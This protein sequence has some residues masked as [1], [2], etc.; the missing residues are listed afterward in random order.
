MAVKHLY[1]HI[2]FCRSRCAYCDFASEP[3]GPHRRSGRVRLYLAALRAELGRNAPLLDVPLDTVYLGGGTPS[4]LPRDELLALVGELAALLPAPSGGSGGRSAEFTMEANPGNLDTSLLQGLA[5]AGVTRLSIGIQ[6]FSAQLR[7]TL[8][9][10]VT[11]AEIAESLAAIRE[12][13]WREWNLDLVFGIPGQTRPDVAS[14]L[15]AALAAA[16]PH[17]SLYDLTYSERYSRLLSS[18]AASGAGADGESGARTG[19]GADGESSA[20]RG[21]G[22]AAGT[23]MAAEAFAEKWYAEAV[24]TLVDAGYERYEVSNFA[25][26]GHECRHNQ[27]YWLGED[28]VGLGASAVSTVA[29]IRRTNPSTVAAYLAGEAPGL[30]EIGDR[31]RMFEKAMLGLR[32]SQGIEE[33]EVLGVL[34]MT[35]LQRLRERGCVER[36]YGRIRLNPGFLDVSNSII[37]ALLEPPEAP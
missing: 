7:A 28:Y 27:A 11:Q 2:P 26:P 12:A 19:A 33:A 34:D 17:I 20:G 24:R 22:M 31:T 25:L 5:E 32:T 9:R 30:E 18:R 4:V 3:I 8:G 13:R 35:A 37:A 10:A 14:D 6:S 16:P 21:A 29:G 15:A 36:H 23:R 1:V